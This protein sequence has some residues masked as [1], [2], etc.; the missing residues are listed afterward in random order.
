[1]DLPTIV[2]WIGTIIG[3]I[4][5]I[6]PSVLF[7]NIHL[8]KEKYT[9][10]PE[11]MLIFN[12]LCPSLWAC[13]WYLQEDKFVP[14]FSAVAGLGISEIFSLLYLYYLSGKCLKK[15]L[16]FALLEINLVIEFN[17]VLIR[18]IGD[19][20]T[21]GNIA[22]VVNILT[23]IAPGQNIIKVCKEKNYKLIPIASTLSGA[24]CA[25][26]WLTFGLL[27]K[28][29]HTIIPNTLGL[30]FAGINSL[31]WAYFYCKRD[32]DSEEDDKKELITPA[33]EEI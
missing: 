7:Y 25:L 32:K 8:G 24:S 33:K 5:N 12:I 27:I 2:S 13:Y 6:S 17:Y 10:I 30:I 11:S 23:Y 18:I 4:L 29:I 19:Y 22:V 3:I 1:M 15:Y 21:V 16:L 28:D 31:I 20:P 26:S 9:I 14:F